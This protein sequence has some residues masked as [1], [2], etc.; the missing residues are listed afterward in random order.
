MHLYLVRHC[1]AMHPTAQAERPLSD[2]GLK[3]AERLASWMGRSGL[4]LD[5]IVH[6]GVLRAQQTAEKIATVVRPT[7]GIRVEQGLQPG[8]SARDAVD[9]LR[10]DAGSRMVVTHLPIIAQIAALLLTG[11]A[12][13][14]P[15]AFRTGT[16]AALVGEGDCWS[17]EWL[18]QPSMLAPAGGSRGT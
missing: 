9:R 11:S 17:L 15:V 3:Q 6:S 16:V 14:E 18:I 8:D 7:R 5:E 13:N 12:R 2:H 10:H 1:D 4:T